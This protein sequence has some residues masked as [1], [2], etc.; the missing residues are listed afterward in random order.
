M[1]GIKHL[2]AA[3]A[4]AS[5]S[6]VLAACNG[7]DSGEVA[8]AQN[9]LATCTGPT[10]SYIAIDASASG[11]NSDLTGARH[12]AVRGELERVA[13]C[14]GRAKVVAFTSSSAGTANLFEDS[15]TLTGATEKAKARRLPQV[16]NNVT[17]Q[18][19]SSYL[20]AL[21]SLPGGGSDP[22][23]QMRLFSEWAAQVGDGSFRLLVI[24]DGLQT[25]GVS[26]EQMLFDPAGSAAH[27][28]TPDLSGTHVSF[29]GIGETAGGTPPT[30]VV[31]A[32]KTFY[33][34]LCARSAA[35]ACTVVSEAAGANR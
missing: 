4:L 21:H 8:H 11:A 33:Q 10:N 12:R 1:K 29:V 28:S 19:A 25:F 7:H 16:A 26:P 5:A 24:S 15:L 31:D 9:L 32:L 35:Q 34:E 13:A 14:G 22:V 18:I 30:Q 6:I 20:E 17:D 3:S 2:L 23:A 27:F